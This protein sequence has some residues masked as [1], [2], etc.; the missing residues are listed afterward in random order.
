MVALHYCHLSKWAP[1]S[2]GVVCKWLSYYR[3]LT[4]LPRK[5][6]VAGVSLTEG[7]ESDYAGFVSSPSVTFG[8]TSPWRGRITISALAPR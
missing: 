8:D 3:H 4:I 7:A 1:A 2:A 5:G 6:E